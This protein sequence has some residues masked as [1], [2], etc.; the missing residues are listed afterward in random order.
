MVAR[1]RNRSIILAAHDIKN[2]LMFERDPHGPEMKRIKKTEPEI[3]LIGAGIPDAVGTT[4]MAN[5]ALRKNRWASVLASRR[6][7]LT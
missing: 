1:S 4:T 6:L 7:R 5:K 3:E 2:R